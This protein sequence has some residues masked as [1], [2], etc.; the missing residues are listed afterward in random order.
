MSSVNEN[1]LVAVLLRVAQAAPRPWYFRQGLKKTPQNEEYVDQIIDVLEELFEE[2]LVQRES[3]TPATGPGVLLTAKGRQVVMDPEARKKLAELDPGRDRSGG[4][5]IHMYGETTWDEA[6]N[7][8]GVREPG[9]GTRGAPPERGEP[10][11]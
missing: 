11:D 3:G 2:G 10:I 8:D 7:P 6:L 9:R 5:L 1:P 4:R